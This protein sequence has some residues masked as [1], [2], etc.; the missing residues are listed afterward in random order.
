MKQWKLEL[1]QTVSL[2]MSGEEGV[3]IGRAEY[4]NMND[5]YLVRY[6]A[7]DGRLVEG[8]WFEE[9]IGSR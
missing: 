5:Q 3:V 7:G 9:A 2:A 6:R 1:G 8:W 4:S